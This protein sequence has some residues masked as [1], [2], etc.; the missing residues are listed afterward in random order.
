[1][2]KL[3]RATTVQLNANRHPAFLTRIGPKFKGTPDSQRF[4]AWA[5]TLPR[6]AE[7]KF[8][9]DPEFARS[10]AGGP[11]TLRVIFLDRGAG[12]LAVQ[13]GALRFQHTLTDSG[14]WQTAGFAIQRASFTE[15]SLAGTTD[16]TL[17]MVGIVRSP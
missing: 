1:V 7:A 4:G 5:R 15:I 10:L 12:S 3:G 11:A 9:L 17:H 16:V 14:R 6:G 13:A 8:G 2:A